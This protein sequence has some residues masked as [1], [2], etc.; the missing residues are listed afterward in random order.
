MKI[1]T[2]VK[3]E[4]KGSSD[5]DTSDLSEGERSSSRPK[6]DQTRVKK[7]AVSLLD[8][9]R[10][11]ARSLRELAR[12]KTYPKGEYRRMKKSKLSKATRMCKLNRFLKTHSKALLKDA[13]ASLFDKLMKDSEKICPADG[14]IERKS[15]KSRKRERKSRRIDVKSERGK[16]KHRRRHRGE[17]KRGEGRKKRRRERRMKKSAANG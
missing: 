12:L 4:L 5:I 7:L 8:R 10:V 17:K 2:F 15:G 3:N 14:R 13:E 11:I 6:L 9:Y 16:R 1:N